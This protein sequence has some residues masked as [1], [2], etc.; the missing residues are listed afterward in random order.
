MV[1][2]YSSPIPVG[3]WGFCLNEDYLPSRRLG[4]GERVFIKYDSNKYSFELKEKFRFLTEIN[5]ISKIIEF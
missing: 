4:K 2:L 3:R 1:W 5:F